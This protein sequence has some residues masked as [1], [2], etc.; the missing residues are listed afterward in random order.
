MKYLCLDQAHCSIAVLNAPDIEIAASTFREIFSFSVDM[1]VLCFP[2][3][4][5][6][7]FFNLQQPMVY[8]IPSGGNL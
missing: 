5:G 8:S 4:D 2:I 1:N 7:L 3:D 6:Q